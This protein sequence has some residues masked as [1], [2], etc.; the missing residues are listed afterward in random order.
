V[1]AALGRWLTEWEQG[2]VLRVGG[3]GC[4]QR[5]LDGRGDAL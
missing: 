4:A 1:V 3:V 2:A 5:E